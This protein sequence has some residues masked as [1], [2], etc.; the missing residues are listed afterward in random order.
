MLT[1]PVVVVSVACAVIGL[2]LLVAIV[3]PVAPA[4]AV[5]DFGIVLTTSQVSAADATTPAVPP[6]VVAPGGQF[7][8]WYG[9][10]NPYDTPTSVDLVARIS[11]FG[12]NY[13]DASGISHVECSLPPQAATV[14]TRL[15]TVS[16]DLPYGLYMVQFSVALSPGSSRNLGSD[17]AEGPDWLVLAPVQPA[18]AAPLPPTPAAT[19]TA[20]AEPEAAATPTEVPAP[21]PDEDNPPSE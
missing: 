8:L 12:V 20:P 14:C 9:V 16:P 4:G 18:I 1:R 7:R 21:E 3:S 2:T 6:V 5:E 15:F 11:S 19:P 13:Q 10:S 17:Y